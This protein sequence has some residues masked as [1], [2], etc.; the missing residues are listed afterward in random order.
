MPSWTICIRIIPIECPIALPIFVDG[1]SPGVDIPA[2]LRVNAVCVGTTA[3][4]G[5]KWGAPSCRP[6][7]PPSA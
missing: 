3:E 7:P 2:P 1:N 5:S 6:P 4:E